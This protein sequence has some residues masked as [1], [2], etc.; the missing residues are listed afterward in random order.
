MGIILV[1]I[2]SSHTKYSP[3]VEFFKELIKSNSKLLKSP[4]SSQYC[5]QVWSTHLVNFLKCKKL[6][7]SI[8]FLREYSVLSPPTPH[9]LCVFCFS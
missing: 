8:N 2:Y 1:Q 9:C 4:Q 3:F 5:Y 7:F 6:Y